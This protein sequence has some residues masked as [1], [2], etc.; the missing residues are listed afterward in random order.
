M[1]V[2]SPYSLRAK[3]SSVPRR[4]LILTCSSIT[5]PSIWWKTGLWV[6]SASSAR[7]TRPGQITLIGSFIFSIA[8]TWTLEVCVRSRSG[9]GWPADTKNVSCMSLAG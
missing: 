2:P 4:S 6:A 3:A 7:Y 5:R 1:V 9:L 8:L